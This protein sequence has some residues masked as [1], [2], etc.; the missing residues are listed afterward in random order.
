MAN[1]KVSDRNLLVDEIERRLKEG[2]PKKEEL[3][4]AA[5]KHF[6]LTS[7]V[8]SID[9][10]TKKIEE[11]EVDLKELE[12][13]R[14]VLIQDAKISLGFKDPYVYSYNTSVTVI[15]DAVIL[16]KEQKYKFPSRKEIVT[17]VLLT[18]G[19]DDMSTLMNKIIEQFKK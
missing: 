19:G 15:N 1:L 5:L 7:H 3:E 2:I 13:K 10:Y 4:K 18:Q 12:G 14:R 8:R 6:K 16:Y 17:A 9:T 11:L